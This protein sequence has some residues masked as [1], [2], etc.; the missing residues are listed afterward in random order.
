MGTNI[1]ILWVDDDSK[2]RISSLEWLIN[3][4]LSANKNEPIQSVK[5]HSEAVELI[6]SG[7][8]NKT[9]L[10]HALLLDVELPDAKSEGTL[11][12]FYGFDLADKA[13]SLG[14][15]TIVFL[16]VVEQSLVAHLLTDLKN[17]YGDV[18]FEYYNKLDA[19]VRAIV[20]DLLTTQPKKLS[21]A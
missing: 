18:Y 3:R 5:S 2:G 7:N 10:I 15:K 9:P 21:E 16:T 6:E 12:R 11:A 4:E 20:K 8:R 13:A 19:P 17:K 14:I 1:R